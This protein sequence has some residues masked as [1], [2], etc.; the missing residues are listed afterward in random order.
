[1][2][3]LWGFVVLI[4]LAPLFAGLQASAQEPWPSRTVRIVVPFP[5]GGSQD[6]IGRL[7]AQHLQQ[8]LGQPFVIE[9]V[10]GAGGGIG[11]DRVAKAAPDGYLLTLS[12][13]GPLANNQLLYKALPYDAAKDFTP[14]IL[15]GEFPMILITKASEATDLK[16]LVERA[17]A[18]PGKLNV[19][20]PGNGTMGHLTAEL[21]QQSAGIKLQ[22]VPYRGGAPAL[23]GMMAGEVQ[24]VSDV[25]TGTAMGMITSGQA[26]GLAVTSRQ[27]FSGLPNTP[28]SV[29]LGFKDLEASVAFALVGPAGLPKPIVDKL[30]AEVNRYINSP[31]GKAK[32]TELGAQIVGGAPEAVT[33]MRE[34]SLKKWKP[35]VEAAGIT[36]N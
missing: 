21:F 28:T 26:T 36:A 25:I 23:V 6:V 34:T 10:P 24:V 33:Q 18:Q 32:L 7:I 29:E 22:H 12:S 31:E 30:N 3:R 11:T 27:R 16:A 14:I 4:M 19:G 35:V 17:R 13:S 2:Q 8:T 15:V 1:M 20:T 5:A 9:N